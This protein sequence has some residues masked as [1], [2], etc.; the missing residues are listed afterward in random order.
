MKFVVTATGAEKGDIFDV[1]ILAKKINGVWV[2]SSTSIFFVDY[3]H[4]RVL[5][6]T[7]EER[8]MPI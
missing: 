1:E 6:M 2:K 8:K 4:I 7:D 5:E 3:S